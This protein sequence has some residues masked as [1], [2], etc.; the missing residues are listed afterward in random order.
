MSWRIS[1][2]GGRNHEDLVGVSVGMTDIDARRARVICEAQ[3]TSPHFTDRAVS[4]KLPD[5]PSLPRE[6]SFTEPLA[7]ELTLIVGREGVFAIA[8]EENG[9]PQGTLVETQGPRLPRYL[10]MKERVG[11]RKL[12]I[13]KLLQMAVHF[14]EVTLNGQESLFEFTLRIQPSPLPASTCKIYC[15]DYEGIRIAVMVEKSHSVCK[16]IRRSIR[17]AVRRFKKKTQVSV[18]PADT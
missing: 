15:Q 18:V 17:R 11:E 9:I 5:V 8:W 7:Q 1:S 6:V 4:G 13:Q 14:D 12:E 2:P 3:G 16:D 10:G